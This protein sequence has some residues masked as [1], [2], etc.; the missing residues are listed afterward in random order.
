M[1]SQLLIVRQVFGRRQVSSHMSPIKLTCWS[2]VF[3]F[4]VKHKYHAVALSNEAAYNTF[5]VVVFQAA[6]REVS[7]TAVAAFEEDR[8]D[9]AACI[10]GQQIAN[11]FCEGLQNP[12]IC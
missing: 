7:L 6:V 9:A 5:A 8:T 3:R 4:V 1:P 2:W 10:A 12:A 11:P